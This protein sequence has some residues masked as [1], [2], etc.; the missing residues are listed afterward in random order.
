M[1][2]RSTVPDTV[3]SDRTV[4]STYSEVNGKFPTDNHY[5]VAMKLNDMTSYSNMDFALMSALVPSLNSGI[6]RVLVSYDIGCQ[7]GKHLQGRLDSYTAFPPIKLSNLKYW[8]VAVPKFHLSGHGDECQVPF[9][10]AFMK[11]AGRVDGERIEAGWAQTNSMATWTRESGPNARRD[12]LDDHWN[13]SNWQKVLGLGESPIQPRL[14]YNLIHRVGKALD[15]NFRRSLAWSK[16]QRE[17][18]DLMSGSYPPDIVDK[19]HEMRDDFDCDPSKPNPY[20]EVEN[21]VSSVCFF[22]LLSYLTNRPHHGSAQAGTPQRG[23]E[24]SIWHESSP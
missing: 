13:A 21:R 15:K 12:I 23:G 7:W 10:L 22:G 6:S 14:L 2:V 8:R 1:L 4:L 16:S 11:G 24:T 5:P 17:I 9:N 20:Q 3:S 19:W 18:A